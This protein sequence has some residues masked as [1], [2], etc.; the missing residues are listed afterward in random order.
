MNITKDNSARLVWATPEAEKVIMYSARVSSNN[1]DSTD[2]RLLDYCI[3]NGHWSIFEMANMCVEIKTSRTIARQILRHRSFSFQE[4]SGRYQSF[5]IIGGQSDL[6]TEPRL[7]DL[8][9][10]QNSVSTDDEALRDW[11]EN[12]QIDAIYKTKELYH[13]AL[14]KGIAKELARNLLPE[15]LTDSKLYMNGTLRSWLHYLDLRTNNGTQQEHIDIANSIK[16]IFK[17]E[18]PI[19]ANAKGW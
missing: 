2:T 18:F 13:L 19:I 8:K 15:G 11:W 10:R 7:Q 6:L 5:D 14:S 1:Q 16:N 12:T 17:K 4:F 3:R 9:N